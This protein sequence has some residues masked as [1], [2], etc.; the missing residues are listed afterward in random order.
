MKRLG[1]LRRRAQ[2]YGLTHPAVGADKPNTGDGG[3]FSALTK[4]QKGEVFIHSVL[5]KIAELE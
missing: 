2:E 4:G 1:T 3:R 5:N